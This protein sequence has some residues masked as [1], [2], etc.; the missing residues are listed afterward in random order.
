MDCM[1]HGRIKGRGMQWNGHASE[2]PAN[3]RDIYILS[4]EDHAFGKA[5]YDK[6][7]TVWPY[8]E[9]YK[10]I[11]HELGRR[12]HSRFDYNEWTANAASSF[13]DFGQPLRGRCLRC[14]TVCIAGYDPR[15]KYFQDNWR[16]RGGR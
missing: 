2:A 11:L 9:A 14:K 1:I 10:A 13:F 5:W 6:H 12:A 4:D 7:G 8:G 16:D 15:M 3:T